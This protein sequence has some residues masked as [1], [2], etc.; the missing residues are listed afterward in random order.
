MKRP[1]CFERCGERRI[2]HERPHE[3]R[4]TQYFEVPDDY[5]IDKPVY[6]S[7]TCAISA[8]AISLKYEGPTKS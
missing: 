8:G 6:C 4:G 3:P 1:C 5:P 7:L 2:H